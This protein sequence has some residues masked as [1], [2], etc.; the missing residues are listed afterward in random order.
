MTKIG[1]FR[2]FCLSAKGHEQTRFHIFLAQG[3][4]SLVIGIL[5][6]TVAELDGLHLTCNEP[7]DQIFLVLMP[8]L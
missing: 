8:L 4:M 3:L 5:M 7:V 6:W 1:D 2:Q